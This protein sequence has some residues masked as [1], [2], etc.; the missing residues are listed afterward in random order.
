MGGIQRVPEWHRSEFERNS[1]HEGT[2]HEGTTI[3]LGDTRRHN[4]RF[5]VLGDARGD[6]D[7]C[8]SDCSQTTH[9]IACCRNPIIDWRHTNN[10]L[11][12]TMSNVL[13][14]SLGQTSAQKRKREVL[15]HRQQ[16]CMT[17]DS[18]NCRNPFTSWCHKHD[19]LHTTMS[20]VLQ[21]SL[22]QT[23]AQKSWAIMGKFIEY[24]ELRH[25]PTQPVSATIAE[26]Q[27]LV[28]VTRTTYYI[29]RC[30]RA[31]ITKQ[32]MRT[33]HNCRNPITRWCHTHDVPH[34]TCNIWRRSR[35]G[36]TVDAI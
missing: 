18:R 12:T 26:I 27:L 28:D 3:T 23:S 20:N 36:R 34:M 25:T 33:S 5:Q 32:V 16:S 17:H 9:A 22:G 8:S 7:S 15:L 4:L 29:R 6:N 10:V 2:C 19:V 1:S 11:Q 24:N 13:P 30:Q 21:R 35:K 14:R 31:S